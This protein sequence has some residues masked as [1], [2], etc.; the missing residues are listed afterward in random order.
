MKTTRTL[1]AGAAAM[2]LAAPAFAQDDNQ[3]SQSGQSAAQEQTQMNG[4]QGRSAKAMQKDPQMVRQ[5]QQ[6]LQDQGYEVGEIDGIWGPKTSNALKEFQRAQGMQA[7]GKL[8]QSAVS[9]LGIDMQ[10]SGSMATGQDQSAGAGTAD[11]SGDGMGGTQGAT[12]AADD[13]TRGAGGQSGT[14]AGA[15]TAAG[16]TGAG[17]GEGAG[18]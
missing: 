8:S 14:G 1:I 2:L 5:I 7:D 15:G 11:A 10:G 16:G 9:A 17:G 12:G 6:K 4:S 3:A 18:R 13:P